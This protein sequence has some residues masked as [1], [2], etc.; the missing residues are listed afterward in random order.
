MDSKFD[1]TTLQGLY[2]NRNWGEAIK[3][4]QSFPAKNATAQ[5]RVNK[6]IDQLKILQAK[7]K[8]WFDKTDQDTQQAYMLHNALQN[9][10]ALPRDRDLKWTDASG[11][12]HIEHQRNKFGTE[13][14]DVIN[15]LVSKD[16][17]KINKIA[18]EISNDDYLKSMGEL[19][20]V[21]D[22]N[23]NNLGIGLVHTS[24]GKKRLEVSLNNNNLYKVVNA[25]NKV[26]SN[27]STGEIIDRIGQN[28]I[29]FGIGGASVGA[30]FEG[31]GA[32]P[33]ALIGA[34]AGLIK[35][36]GEEIYNSVNVDTNV[37]IKGIDSDNNIIDKSDFNYNDLKKAIGVINTAEE[38]YNNSYKGIKEQSEQSVTTD[39]EV[40]QFYGLGHAEAYK[41]MQENKLSSTEYDK[42][43]ER[44]KEAYKSLLNTG[45][46]VDKEVYAWKYGAEGDKPKTGQNLTRI[47]NEDL[48][49]LQGEIMLAMKEDRLDMNLATMGGELGTLITIS[50]K[51]NNEK[52][53]KKKGEEQT[54]IFVKGLY[55]ESAEKMV[56]RSTK[57]QAAKLAYDMKKDNYELTLDSGRTVGYES[58]YGAYTAYIDPKDSKVKRQLLSDEQFA[59]YLNEHFIIKDV[60]NNA[61][62]NMNSNGNIVQIGT[63]GKKQEMS[64]DEYCKLMS[65]SA[66]NELIDNGTIDELDLYTYQGDIFRKM[67]KLIEQYITIYN[68]N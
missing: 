54:K 47:N 50:P 34:S 60:A 3:Y 18:I 10:G 45:G 11:K 39:I 67:K 22:F 20:G 64:I 7:D 49:N 65:I 37:Q 48:P 14:I 13:Y 21:D 43:T 15:S 30:F 38:L 32:I 35:G 63:N 68:R 26:T 58:G 19:L 5:I 61:I 59:G 1:K 8:S 56:E 2:D 44:W 40:T 16:N 9:N 57:T 17:K 62:A 28:I 31:V 25:A 42:V 4:L 6:R 51:H 27:G 24:D 41:A 12:E 46:I 53:S 33:G 55:E 23:N 66:T 52:W 36:V 29:S